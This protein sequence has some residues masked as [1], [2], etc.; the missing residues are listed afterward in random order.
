[1]DLQFKKEPISY[2]RTVVNEIQTQEQ[3][4][5][6][7]LPDGMPDVGHV[8]SA[9]A[10]VLIR[11]KEWRGG[12]IGVNGGVMVWVLYGPEDGSQLQCMET[13]LPFQMKWDMDTG[14]QDGMICATPFLQSVDA[15]SVSARKIIV[16]AGIGILVHARV[17]DKAEIGI[18]QELPE[19]VCVLKNVYPMMLAADSGEKA[20]ALEE[21]LELP[22]SV[23]AVEKIVYYN[24]YPDTTDEKIMTDK[25]IFR[26]QVTLC[27]LYMGTDGQ[28]HRWETELP[29]SQYAELGRD[30]TDSADSTMQMAVTNL[31]L[32]KGENGK[33]LLKAGLLGQYTVYDR[34]EV[35]VVEDAYSPRRQIT[36]YTEPLKLPSMLDTA[37]E[38]VYAQQ[39]VEN[40][41]DPVTD[42]LFYPDMPRTYREEEGVGT[43][44]SGTFSVLGTNSEGMPQSAVQM[45]EESRTLPAAPG[46][47][48][49]MNLRPAKVNA[50]NGNVEAEM[51]MDVRFFTDR[52]M[53]MITGMELGEL[54]ESDPDR[55][56]LILRKR[57][58]QS[59]W[60][61]A[62]QTGSTVET[63]QRANGI[64]QEP[65]PDK[66]LLIPVL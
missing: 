10:Q 63:I 16:R 64:T 6:V 13:W 59:L 57:G 61:I 29:F 58:E 55:P 42:V 56:S 51:L 50:S 39:T 5:E 66:M 28:L 33:L 62:K 31:E 15:R 46:V 65:D 12:S 20:F 24:L 32:E 22:A 60:D 43:D 53:P 11:G 41:E 49:E 18:P 1:M 25:L 44:M 34:T 23:P 52:E 7:R 35:A 36:A 21:N 54:Q 40:M 26:G 2:L 8:I 47:R 14:V 17:R 4:Q 37:T 45:W 48:A 19:D 3:T 27:L 38:T 30:C 9:W